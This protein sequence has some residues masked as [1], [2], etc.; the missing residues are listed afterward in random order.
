MNNL[1][2]HTI[3]YYYAMCCLAF[4]PFSILLFVIRYRKTKAFEW[5]NKAIDRM[6]GE[7]PKEEDR[8][9]KSVV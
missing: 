1:D 3:L 6:L 7:A 9:R 4:S 5:L 8:D 2:F